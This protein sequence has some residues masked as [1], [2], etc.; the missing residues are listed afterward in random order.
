MRNG[1]TQGEDKLAWDKWPNHLIL[2]L[3]LQSG[4]ETNN[5][6]KSGLAKARPAGPPPPP[7]PLPLHNIAS[8]VMDS[9]PEFVLA[10]VVL[11]L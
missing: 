9:V 7:P 2:R 11:S 8:K 6:L 10:H 4:N 3:S 5:P 1:Y